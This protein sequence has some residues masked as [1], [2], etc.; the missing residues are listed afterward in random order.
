MDMILEITEFD[1][2][3]RLETVTTMASA[4][5][6]GAL[7]F[8]PAEGGT[9]MGWEWD[10]EPNGVLRLLS[11]LV[12]WVGKRQEDAIWAGLKRHLESASPR[13]D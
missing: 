7:T 6:R 8:E 3:T 2:P 9:R 5:V 11:P 10:V 4:N 12:A 13:G 1:R